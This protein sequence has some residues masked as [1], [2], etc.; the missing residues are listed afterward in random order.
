MAEPAGAA[1][2]LAARLNYAQCWEDPSLLLRALAPGPGRHLLSVASAG[3]NAIALAL[4]GA[5]VTAVDLSAPQLACAELKLAGRHLDLPAFRRLLG[6]DPA[7][8]RLA[9]YEGLRE[10][11][12]DRARA[13][14]D[15]RRELL[16]EGLLGA[17]RFERYLTRFRTRVLPL[18]HRARTARAWFDL[19]DLDAQRRFF[20]ERWDT[21]RWRGLFRLFFSRR[22]MA[23]MGRS[24]EQFAH[25]E[26]EVS[27]ALLRRARW[28]LTELPVRDNG[29]LQWMLTGGWVHPEALP[30]YLTP[31]GHRR[32]GEAAGR[33][34]LVHASLEDHLATVE[35]ATYDGFNL[36]DVFEYLSEDASDALMGQIARAGRPGARL[37]YWN[38]FVPRQRP[39]HLA[40]VLV[41]QE[42]LAAELSRQDRAFVYDAFRVEEVR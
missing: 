23:A 12:S 7:R 39:A 4:A 1:S 27:E 2:P 16:A 3:D 17:G 32:L 42:A 35:E 38:L 11:L 37:G 5:R 30:P 40:D 41:P 26:G 10:G 33:I 6:V 18:V 8:D 28:V 14:F 9:L 22:V 19:D 36:S 31:E 24:P 21:W 20:T 25:V 29:Y 15:P 13:F 34:A